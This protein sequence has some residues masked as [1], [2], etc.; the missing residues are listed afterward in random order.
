[1]LVV[2]HTL[3]SLSQQELPL[4]QLPKGCW[5]WVMRCYSRDRGKELK[6][7]VGH[8][9]FKFLV[10]YALWHDASGKVNRTSGLVMPHSYYSPAEGFQQLVKC[11]CLALERH[12][13]C[14]A[15]CLVGGKIL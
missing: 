4:K 2:G 12:P 15:I 8:I 10:A 5:L 1:M 9:F 7:D 11:Q 14:R 13:N 6:A 3:T